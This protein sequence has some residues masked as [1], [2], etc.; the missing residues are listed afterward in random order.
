[1]NGLHPS[2]TIRAFHPLLFVDRQRFDFRLIGVH[3]FYNRRY[4][5]LF[6]IRKPRFQF[7]LLS[8]YLPGRLLGDVYDARTPPSISV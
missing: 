6:Q 3:I 5:G 4:Y 1:M 7:W 2:C 8:S